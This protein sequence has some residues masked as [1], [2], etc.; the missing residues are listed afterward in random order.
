MNCF[1]AQAMLDCVKARMLDCRT[2]SFGNTVVAA[3]GCS[4]NSEDVGIGGQATA[5]T[6]QIKFNGGNGASSPGGG[7]SSAGTTAN[8]NNAFGRTGGIAP[9]GG[10]NGGSIP[11]T[12]SSNGDDGDV[13]G[14]GGAG[15]Q[16]A[17][18]STTSGNGAPGQVIVFYYQILS[19]SATTPICLGNSA[20]VTINST[21]LLAGVS[22]TVTYN[23][24]AGNLTANFTATA[25]SG[26]FTVPA[27]ALTTSGTN[28]VTITQIT[29][30]TYAGGIMSLLKQIVFVLLLGVYAPGFLHRVYHWFLLREASTVILVEGLP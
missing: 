6:G 18:G 20:N 26:T 22:Y 29:N 7:G 24:S 25:G 13:P 3:G 11:G 16:G 14:G 5:S 12:G 23:L 17:G 4:S 10:G 15:K 9:D 30:G 27:S 19:L 1:T 2:S 28:T 8:G 21:S